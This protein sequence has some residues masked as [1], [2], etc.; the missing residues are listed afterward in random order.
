MHR[1]AVSCR[2]RSSARRRDMHT[3][4]PPPSRARVRWTTAIFMGAA[5]R[6]AGAGEGRGGNRARRGGG[7]P[8]RL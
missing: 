3:R 6:L 8:P 2:V 5:A 7:E 1:R 4:S